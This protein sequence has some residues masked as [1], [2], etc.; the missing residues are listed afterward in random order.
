ML[1]KKSVFSPAISGFIGNLKK[2]FPTVFS[3]SF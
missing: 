3:R 1:M 2:E